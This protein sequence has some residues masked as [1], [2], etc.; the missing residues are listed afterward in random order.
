MAPL[1]LRAHVPV[2]PA[3]FFTKALILWFKTSLPTMPTTNH[4]AGTLPKQTEYA[5]VL[6]YAVYGMV[7]NTFA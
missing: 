3:I 6:M 1:G 7:L 2:G 4:A 5:A